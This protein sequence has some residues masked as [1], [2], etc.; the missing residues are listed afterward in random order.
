M[1]C[2]IRVLAVRHRTLHRSA[3]HGAQSG[4]AVGSGVLLGVGS[5]PTVGLK[6]TIKDQEP[7][8][9]AMIGASFAAIAA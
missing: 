7:E 5:A 9:A 2:L 1:P 3:G 8:R 6:A 4:D